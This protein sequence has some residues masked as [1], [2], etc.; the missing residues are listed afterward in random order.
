MHASTRPGRTRRALPLALG[1]GAL[2]LTACGG[3]DEQSDD[4]VAVVDDTSV[5][6]DAGDTSDTTGDPDA[7]QPANS[8]LTSC[9][10][11]TPAEVDSL[12]G[13][14]GTTASLDTSLGL[15]DGCRYAS[16]ATDVPAVV[17]AYAID[18]P[19]ADISARACEGTEALAMPGVAADA[20]SCYDTIIA[21]AGTGVLMAHLEDPSDQFDAEAETALVAGITGAALATAEF[22]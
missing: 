15:Y 19:F 12:L 4:T 8:G 7:A 13:T 14:T 16:A 10:L 20:V 17:L 5:D 21:P 3:D 1:L 22:G 2:L 11:L 18:M 9:D 6:T